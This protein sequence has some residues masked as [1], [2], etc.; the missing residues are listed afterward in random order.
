MKKM[1]PLLGLGV[2]MSACGTGLIPA[3]PYDLPDINATLP[4]PSTTA[5]MVIYS[6][7]D[8]FAG[9]PAIAQVISSIDLT[10]NLVYNGNGPLSTLS[11]VGVYIR[12][13]VDGSNCY[14]QAGYLICD[15]SANA[16]AKYKL[17]DVSITKG[18]LQ[19]VTLTGP[20]L[21]GAVKNR[22]GYIGFRINQGSTM[23]ND[24]INFTKV[25]A[26]IHF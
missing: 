12:S 2:L 15:D 23:T 7:Q 5:P 13:T 19:S 24:Q 17:Q 1:L 14:N 8:Q 11:N 6:T 16:E 26:T 9:L 3:V 25:R 10:G 22:K 18:N 21:N 4:V 20:V